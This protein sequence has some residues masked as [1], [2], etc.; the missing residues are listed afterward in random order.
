MAIIDWKPLQDLFARHRHFVIT[1]HVRPDCDAL[2]SE[3]GLAEIL[4]RMGKQVTIVN[5]DGIPPRLAFIDPYQQIRV[6]HRD[7]S[8]DQ[9][10]TVEAFVVVDTSVWVQVGAMGD[11]LRATHCPIGV[12]DH[13]ASD[14]EIDATVMCKDEHAEATG[15]LIVELAR[16]LGV[17][18]TPVMARPLFAAVATDTGW[19]RFPSTA[20]STFR[21]AGELL[22]AGAVPHE[23]YQMLYEQDTM[24]RAKLRGIALDHLVIEQDGRLAYTYLLAEDFAKTAADRSETED[25]VN[26]ALTISGTEVAMLLSEQSNGQFRVSFRSRAGAI[27]CSVVAAQ[28]HG[29]GHRAAAGAT[30][31]GPFPAARDALLNVVR[32]ALTTRSN[33]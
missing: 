19:F 24:A 27:D 30:L 5:A 7:V 17:R 20:S 21:V 26:M 11:V 1:S 9:L 29:G 2:G 16:H 6:L 22:D 31:D 15:R 8:V 13:H 4:R 32:S 10:E 12:I 23:I 25:F 18:L 3:L 33:T 28:F 14:G